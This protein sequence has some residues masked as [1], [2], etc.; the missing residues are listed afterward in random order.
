[1]SHPSQRAAKHAALPLAACAVAALSAF[2]APPTS[3]QALQAQ[4]IVIDPYTGR[5]RMPEHDEI[6]AAQA[7]TQAARAASRAAAPSG[8]AV[9]STLQAHP[10][11]QLMTAKPLNA[12]LGAKGYRLD[13]SRLAFSVV[14]RNAD[15]TVSTQCVTGGDAVGK[16]LSGTQVGEQH[17]H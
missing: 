5:A 15:G 13:S 14:R 16:V 2:A 17:D 12:Q 6:A 10:A 7:Q 9:K 3:A 1:M 11:A 8:N 4:R